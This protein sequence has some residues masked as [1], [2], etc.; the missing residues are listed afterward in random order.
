MS[1]DKPSSCQ[2]DR[3]QFVGKSFS[4]LAIPVVASITPTLAVAQSGA[5][6][7]DPLG[8]WREL[9]RLTAK[10]VEFGISVPRMSARI[11][12]SDGSDYM[13]IMPA[14]VELIESLETS[15]PRTPL[16][17]GEVEKLI[18]EADSL[19][20]RVHQAERN[21]PDERPEGMSAA[22]SPGRPSFESVKDEYRT[23]FDTCVVRDKY[24]S[25]VEWYISKIL[26]E[27][28]QTQWYK[29]AQGACCPWYFVSIIHAMEAAFNFRSHLH[30]GDSLS[31][32]T[33]QIPRG[34]PKV[35]NPPND[36]ESSA[37]DALAYD[38][39]VDVQ[40]WSLERILYRWELY[41]GVRSRANG[42]NTPYLWSFSNHYSKGKF[43]ADN[44]WDP[45]AV[46]KQ[47]G[48]AVMLKVLADRK[49]VR[50]PTA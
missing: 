49:L 25:T 23:L 12:L 18:E 45:N 3:R 46:S 8:D 29:V 48:A 13:Q 33:K 20:R 2:L 6:P 28:S 24:R 44:V 41:N 36:W 40:D 30:N 35:W 19:L 42:I 50:L 26:K 22:T 16:P 43:V 5:R 31:S 32:R 27:N 9:G 4:T 11:D 37:I 34:R 47:C 14:T 15:Q 21:L 7:S 39:F 10:A 17:P 38:G 1:K